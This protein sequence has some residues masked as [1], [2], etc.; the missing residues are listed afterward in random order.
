MK[1]KVIRPRFDLDPADWQPAGWQELVGDA[2]T[3]AAILFPKV[4]RLFQRGTS[5]RYV[6]IGPPGCG[7]SALSKLLATRLAG[8]VT[9][10]EKVSGKNVNADKVRAWRDTVRLGNL[11]GGYSVKIIEE[12]DAATI[13]ASILMLDYL[14][15]VRDSKCNAVIA[16]SNKAL[17]DLFPDRR[18]YS[19]FQPF[20]FSPVGFSEV[21]ELLSARFGMPQADAENIA[22][23]CDGDLRA[24]LND[25][26]SFFDLQAVAA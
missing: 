1:P 18:L 14:D 22:L 11:F 13:D 16:S 3:A 2:Y 26:Q 5:H 4:E 23:G 6:F 20:V 19:R 24:A 12:I 21:T 25:A 10:I 9:D 8:H 7:K 15:E 17:E